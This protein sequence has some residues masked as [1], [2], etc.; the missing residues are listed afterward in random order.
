MPNATEQK[1]AWGD[2]QATD[3]EIV[4]MT[5]AEE[6]LIYDFEMHKAYGWLAR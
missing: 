3:H 2:R 4:A 1:I 5:A 6:R